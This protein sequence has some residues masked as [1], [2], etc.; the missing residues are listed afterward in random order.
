M[1]LPNLETSGTNTRGK[2]SESLINV[3]RYGNIGAR[4]RVLSDKG[5]GSWTGL[6]TEAPP[7]IWAG[8]TSGLTLGEALGAARFQQSSRDQWGRAEARDSTSDCRVLSRQA[9]CMQPVGLCRCPRPEAP[10]TCPADSTNR[11]S[12]DMIERCICLVC[13]DVPG[14]GELSDTHRALQ[15][16]HG[17]GCSFNG[18]NRWY[19]KSLQ[20]SAL[21]VA[22]QLHCLC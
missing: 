14:T 17:G 7:F 8:R 22:W 12:L 10:L 13:L 21:S 15:L 2:K 16:L 3:H 9:G 6:G 5:A 20:V 18:A 19:D 4:V 11:D 1:K